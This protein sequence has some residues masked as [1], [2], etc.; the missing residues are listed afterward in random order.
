MVD[1]L[2]D[3]KHENLLTPT[4]IPEGK[5]KLNLGHSR[6]R[7]IYWRQVKNGWVPTK[8]LPADPA[9]ISYYFSKGFRAKPPEGVKS[10]ETISCPICGFEA[11]SAF[12]LQA[13]LRK[14]IT[15]SKK[16]EK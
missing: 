10:K 6:M 3:L 2:V 15:K 5:A 16:E 11:K 1:E 8:P 13:H 9:S 4:G 14:H 12:G 7:A